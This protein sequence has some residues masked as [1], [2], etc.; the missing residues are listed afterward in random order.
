MRTFIAIKITPERK[1]LDVF[2]TFKKSLAGEII[3]WVTE[4]NLHVTLRFLGETSRE[5]IA[6]IVKLLEKM[7]ELFQPFQFELKG[8]EVFKNKI[9]P[10]VLFLSIENSLI[11][12]QLA[13]EME[14]KIISLGFSH[15]EK[16]FNPH[17]TLGRIRYIQGKDI[18]YSLVNKFKSVHIQLVTVS[19]I[20]FYQ[21][22]LGS[23]GP[24]Y[25]P[26][27]IIKLN[28]QK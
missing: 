19:E 26:I 24:T 9:Q 1:L 18:F 3:N 13:E 25:H 14:E 20:I 7:G 21:S 2:S 11:L 8:V 15:G 27:K 6:E 10:R 23:E 5:Q 12:K 22:I 28:S 4:N 16:T 17:L